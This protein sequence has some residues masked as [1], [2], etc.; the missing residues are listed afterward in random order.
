M[1]TSFEHQE[2]PVW[3]LTGPDGRMRMYYVDEEAAR[4]ALADLKAQ[5]ETGFQIHPGKYP[6]AFMGK[7]DREAVSN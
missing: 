2:A 3:Y 7:A 5:G 4:Q 6:V 1:T